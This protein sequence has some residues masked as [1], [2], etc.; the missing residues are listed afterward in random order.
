[1]GYRTTK[2]VTPLKLLLALV[3]LWYGIQLLLPDITRCSLSPAK[4]M[5]LAYL[6][7]HAWN[8]CHGH[9]RFGNLDAYQL[10]QLASKRL[11]GNPYQLIAITDAGGATTAIVAYPT[12]KRAYRYKWTHRLLTFNFEKYT[13]PTYVLYSDEWRCDLTGYSA[14]NPPTPEEILALTGN[15]DKRYCH[16]WPTNLDCAHPGEH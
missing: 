10:E 3:V 16:P 9:E 13:A 12:H 14:A 2:Q 7:G 15:H 8:V 1:M 4:A 11:H 5:V 6:H